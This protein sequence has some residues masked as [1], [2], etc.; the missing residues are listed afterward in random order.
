MKPTVVK[1]NDG[2]EKLGFK[3]V[4]SPL[5]RALKDRSGK[6]V[7]CILDEAAFAR[8]D[9][10]EELNSL[11]DRDGGIWVQNEAG[12]AEF[13]QRPKDFRLILASNT[14]GYAGVNLQSEALRSRTHEIYMDFEFKAEELDRLLGFSTGAEKAPEGPL[15]AKA[16]GDEAKGASFNPA[17]PS[18]SP[19]APAK[20]KGAVRGVFGFTPK[21]ASS[22]RRLETFDNP[23]RDKLRKAGLEGKVPEETVRELESRF[24]GLKN[25]L[26]GAA[27]SMGRTGNITLE[28]DLSTETA[29]MQ[30]D[31]PRVFR[32]GPD[33]LLKY[34]V[35]DM[36][37]VAQHE[38]GHADITR[39]GTGYFFRSEKL[40]SLLNVVEDLR[41]NARAM[42]RA[43][44]RRETYLGFLK[45]YYYESYKKVPTER[46][47]KL[48]PHEAF[49]QAVM[50]KVYG[51]ESPWDGDALVGPALREALP[52]IEKAMK[53][54]PKEDNPEEAQVQ[55]DFAKFEEI[56]KGEILP[57]YERLYQES[58]KEVEKRLEEAAKSGEEGQEGRGSGR[59]SGRGTIDPRDLSEKAKKLL[60]E[61][62]KRIADAHAPKGTRGDQQ[63]Q[64]REIYGDPEGE[65]GQQ[66]GKPV[67]EGSGRPKKEGRKGSDRLEDFLDGRYEDNRRHQEAISKQ[68]YSKALG[69]LGQLPN[70]V[71]QVF[72]QL[73]KPN[74]DFEYEG[75]FTSGSKIDVMRA[76]KAI[77]GMTTR[78]NVFKRKT[79]ATGKDYRFSLLLDASGSMADKGERQ[80]GGLGLA[81]LFMDVFERLNLP[82]SLDAF[83]NG[84]IPIKGFEK[85][86]KTAGERN[87]LFNQMVLDTWGGGGT[88]LRGGITGSLKRIMAERKKDSREREF[89]FVLTDGEE[90]HE[91]GPEIRTL[92]EQAAK[93]GVIVVGIGIGE[94]METVRR[95]FPVYLTEKNP[96]KLPVLMAE[97][98][99]EYVKSQKEED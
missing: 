7:T 85:G 43:P 44:G 83:H 77:H 4:P 36:L 10:L 16:E 71:F 20:G 30:L 18:G 29:S 80:R 41:V 76:V 86:V 31:E 5:V 2:T 72:D 39:I 59:G 21:V 78:L 98:I 1:L 62:A 6:P 19:F 70:R 96:E 14:Y 79:E 51:G 33:F 46:L 54:R 40:R 58:L 38:G 69:G 12:K 65:A 17:T 47:P 22:P 53:S 81:A 63:G 92:C 64:A 91:E 60:E 93:E 34:G 82:Y 45:G 89:L 42:D 99:K 15:R 57:I 24:A 73:L 3:Q 49:L 50:S 27:A 9:V 23:V 55:A 74:T 68:E 48:L 8:P 84:Y 67:G 25:R 61:R 66:E 97:F 37:T 90:T 94:G 95:N 26:L 88:N 52:H 32:V 11:L 87:A 75:H 56:L 35:E 28:L 13:I